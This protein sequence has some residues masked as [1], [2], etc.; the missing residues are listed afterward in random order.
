VD[1]QRRARLAEKRRMGQ[2]RLERQRVSAKFR[3]V[4]PL[5]C[6]RSLRFSRLAPERCRAALGPLTGGPGQDERLLWAPIANGTCRSWETQAE[7]D[8][9]LGEALAGCGAAGEARVA[10]IWHPFES[11][12]RIGAGD[13]ARH[14]GPVLELGGGGTIWVVA[15]EGGPWLIEMAYWDREVCWTPSMPIFAGGR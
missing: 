3:A 10:V 2:L 11:G 1:E 4:A 6:E 5:L 9:L 15:A 8:A 13:L 7:R 14:A 12:L